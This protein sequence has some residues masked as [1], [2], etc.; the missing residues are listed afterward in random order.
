MTAAVTLVGRVALASV[1][2]VA[3]SMYFTSWSE[4]TQHMAAEGLPAQDVLLAAA[5][6][7]LIAGGLSVVLGFYTQWGATLLMIFLLIVTPIFHDFW[8]MTGQ[9]RQMQQ[10]H[11]LSN[12]AKF[13]GLLML[14]AHGPGRWSLDRGKRR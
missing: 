8:T 3:V 4:I 1:F 13:G 10:G 7:V 5:T 9:E 2:L 6:V 12:L 11:F 14:W